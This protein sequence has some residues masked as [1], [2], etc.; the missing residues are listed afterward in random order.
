MRPG[1]A[2]EAADIEAAP[3]VE[4]R[5]RRIGR[6]RSGQPHVGAKRW[7][8]DT[9]ANDNRDSDFLHANAPKRCSAPW[10][11]TTSLLR[12]MLQLSHMERLSTGV[13]SEKPQNRD[14]RRSAREAV[15]L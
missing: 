5:R 13:G 11:R 15:R 14:R 9:C 3:I 7:R 10:K 2:A 6:C 4:H 8:R 1:V 12:Y